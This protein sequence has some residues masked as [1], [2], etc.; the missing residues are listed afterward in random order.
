MQGWLKV[1][2]LIIATV[3]TNLAM[4]QENN[5]M[6]TNTPYS[7][8]GL[9][10]VLQPSFTSSIGMGG[11]TTGV[12]DSRQIDYMNPAGASMRDSLTFI[13]DFGLSMSNNYLKSANT[14]SSSNSFNFHHLA[15]AF[16]LGSTKFGANVG[17]TPYS[18][19]DY[20]IERK[21]RVNDSLILEAGDILY[22][23]KGQDGI[24][25]VFFNLGYDIWR[26]SLGVGAQ[27]YFGTINRYY[28]TL[29]NF[30]NTTNA[31]YYNTYTRSSLRINDFSF[32]LGA[33][34]TQSFSAGR[35][36]VAGFSIQPKTN[37]RAFEDAVTYVT[38]TT[39]ASASDTTN[40]LSSKKIQIAM[41]T[42]INVGLSYT[43]MDKW[44]LGAEF[45]YQD[46][47][48][49]SIGD[50]VGEMGESYTVRLGGHYTPN[51]YDV[52]YFL[53]RFTY[54]GGVRIGQSP[55]VYNGRSVQDMAVSVGVG[56]PMRGFG[57]L[58]F[59]CEVGQ[60]GTT[61]HGMVKETYV[62]FTFS[63]SIFEY[64]F[65]KYKYE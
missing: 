58:N 50:R 3:T 63:M 60:R 4:A 20:D 15:F 35:S 52:R 42:H 65:Q 9:G 38:P 57:N 7:L 27:Y 2:L 64:W 46:W 49:T 37:I 23:Y 13:V 32:S 33:Q 28:N 59:S 19:V 12:R 11:I 55:M 17:I 48:K 18:F 14:S 53:K 22:Q 39:G 29:F 43:K 56:V 47:S 41:P 10:D 1:A 36:L 25:K 24:N 5:G 34:Y 45:N 16:P 40:Y 30:G 61:S 44:M 51:K 6:N 26:F 21:E 62:N 31:N 54:R 8:F